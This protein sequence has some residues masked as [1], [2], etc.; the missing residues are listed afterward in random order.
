M[1]RRASDRF[2]DH[3]SINPPECRIAH[4]NL[5]R[6]AHDLLERMTVRVHSAIRWKLAPRFRQGPRDTVDVNWMVF[7][8]T[9]AEILIDADEQKIRIFPGDSVFLSP[10]TKHI[11]ICRAT[12][13]WTMLSIHMSVCVHGG[14]DVL[15]MLGFPIRVADAEGVLLKLAETIINE[16]VSRQPGWQRAMDT[17]ATEA[18]FHITR[19]AGSAFRASAATDTQG[20]LRLLPVLSE[21]ERRLSDPELTVGDLARILNRT[22]AR[23]R[24]LFQAT[25]G[26]S[27]AAYIRQGRMDLACRLLR[28]SDMPIKEIAQRCGFQELSFFYRVFR[29]TTH[30]SPAMWRGQGGT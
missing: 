6:Y 13:A 8:D 18:L 7:P 30:T 19:H 1:P 9:K 20:L 29:A 14:A 15:R 26:M 11:E 4:S 25:I 10:G 23:L 28:D 12:H 24:M 17:H 27:P 3:G 2:S 21:V 16:E 22:P 5:P